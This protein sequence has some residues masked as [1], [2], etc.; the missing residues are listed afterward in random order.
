[1]HLGARVPQDLHVPA[2]EFML[3]HKIGVVPPGYSI[4]MDETSD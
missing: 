1:M 2:D 4:I 3:F